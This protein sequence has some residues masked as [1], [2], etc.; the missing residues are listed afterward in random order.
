MVVG[1]EVSLGAAFRQGG[2]SLLVAL[3][4][5]AVVQSLDNAA[6]GVLAPD[7]QDAARRVERRARRHRRG[8]GRAVRDGRHPHRRAGRPPA[9][10]HHR[11]GLHASPTACCRSPPAAVGNAFWLF[12]ARMGSGLAASHILPGAQ[13][14]AGRRLPDQDARPDLL[15]L[16][17]RHA[18]RPA[19]RPGRRSA[20]S[21]ALVGGDRGLAVGLR[22]RRR[23]G[24]RRCRCSSP[25]AASRSAGMNEQIAVLGETI[26]AER[27]P[28]PISTSIAFARLQQISTFRYMLIG[29]GALGFGLFSVPIFLNIFMEDTFGLVGV[30]AR[31]GRLDRRGARRCSRCR[32]SAGSTTGCSA[33]RRRSRWCCAPG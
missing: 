27:S 30:R 16:R 2:V 18:D 11:R 5:V 33:R 13:L 7:I 12:V 23:A 22:R 32:S 31:R 17:A 21:P 9:A 6:L 26:E 24:A 28:V 3:M 10:H 1:D 29:I 20:P 25:R 14:A 15:D 19:A 4:A 8:G